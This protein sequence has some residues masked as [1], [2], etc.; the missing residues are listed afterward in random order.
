MEMC[1]PFDG[2]D[3]LV[4]ILTQRHLK[5]TPSANFFFS[6]NFILNWHF[7]ITFINVNILLALKGVVH[8]Y[9]LF[10]FMIVTGNDFV[11]KSRGILKT[12]HSELHVHW[13]HP[14]SPG[15]RETFLMFR[16]PLAKFFY[17]GDLFLLPRYISN[18]FG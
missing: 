16:S 13:I 7:C 1:D 4:E 9:H 8:Y 6:F 11:V 18:V 10:V 3:I 15:K 12:I 5:I 14:W 17:L 2:Q